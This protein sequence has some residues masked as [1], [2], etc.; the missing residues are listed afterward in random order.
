MLYISELLEHL[1]ALDER[2]ALMSDLKF[3]SKDI[4]TSLR[5]TIWA[6]KKDSYTAEDCLLRIKNFVQ[7]LSRYYA[8]IQFNI[9]GDA[10]ASMDL[11]YTKALNLVRIVQEAVTNSIK[12]GNARHISITSSQTEG[13]WQ[14]AVVDDGK[15][16]NYESMKEME[17]GNGLQNMR[18]RAADSGFGFSILSEPA[19]GTSIKISVG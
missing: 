10:P 4:I 8:N 18:Q 12:H 16:F 15:G 6:L 9:S 5:E 1:N 13:K 14:L 17:Q 19:K 3:A 11:H 7:P 2:A